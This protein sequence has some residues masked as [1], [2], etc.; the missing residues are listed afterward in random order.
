MR[1]AGAS[2]DEIKQKILALKGSH[3]EMNINRGRKKFDSFSGIV[4]D[5]YPS[6]FTVV[7]T[8]GAQNIQ[9]FSYYD[10]LCGNVV[11]L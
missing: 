7:S 8:G 5:V 11:F 2:L 3:V 9:T 4:K 6:V 10:V 1:K